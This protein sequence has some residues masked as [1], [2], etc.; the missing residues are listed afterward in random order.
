MKKVCFL[1][2]K[3]DLKIKVEELSPVEDKVR[4]IRKALDPKNVTELKSFQSMVNYYG[5]FIPDLS[6]VLDQMYIL[7]YSDNKWLWGEQQENAYGK[8]KE[9]LQSAKLLVHYH[10]AKELTL[11]CDVSPYRVGVVLS[12]IMEDGSEKPIGLASSTLTAA[13]NGYAQLD[14]E[15]PVT[16]FAVEF[17]SISVYLNFHHS[18]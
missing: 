7:L 8:V 10:P 2:T 3:C 16:V 1:S 9:L 11:S 13:A 5:R 6:K 18:Y 15:E 12:H 4:T 14:K 17:S